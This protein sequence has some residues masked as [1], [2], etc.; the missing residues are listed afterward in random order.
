LWTT[1]WHSGGRI[2]GYETGKLF[3][4]SFIRQMHNISGQYFIRT[5][6]IRLHCNPK[7]M[8]FAV[9]NRNFPLEIT[10]RNGERWVTRKQLELEAAL[11]VSN[12]RMLHA[13]LVKRHELK[14][15]THFIR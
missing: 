12:I 9:N 8:I 15:G 13:R 3:L 4:D 6:F 11:G 5:D 1:G 2:A 14:E 7:I 10:D